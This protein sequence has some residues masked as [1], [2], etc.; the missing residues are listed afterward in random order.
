M[1]MSF[2]IFTGLVLLMA[3]GAV[4]ADYFIDYTVEIKENCIKFEDAVFYDAG[5]D[6]YVDAG[7]GE[8]GVIE[9]D[10]FIVVLDGP[11]DEASV[12]VKAGGGNN[13]KAYETV[14]VGDAPIPMGAFLVEISDLGDNIYGITVTYDDDNRTAALS[15][16]ELCFCEDVVAWAYLPN[17]DSPNNAPG[18]EEEEEEE[19]VEV[20]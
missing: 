10:E 12:V 2:M 3:V 13:G 16:I 18:V 5:L 9:T 8:E 1:K 4:W 11:C 15:Y 20:D 17:R 14:V 6:D 7:L 19:E